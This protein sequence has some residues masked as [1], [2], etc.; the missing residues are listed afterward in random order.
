MCEALQVPT[1]IFLLH[2]EGVSSLSWSSW[3]TQHDIHV[4]SGSLSDIESLCSENQVHAVFIQESL[5][6]RDIE[7]AVALIHQ[8][9]QARIVGMTHASQ[10]NLECLFRLGFDEILT[11]QMSLE[12]QQTRCLK[13]LNEGKKRYALKADYDELAGSYALSQKQNDELILLSKADSLTG[14]FNRRYMMRK[15]QEEA[16]RN[17]RSQHNTFS[18]LVCDIDHFDALNAKEGREIG[19]RVLREVALILTNS[20]RTYDIISRW[21]GDQFMLLLPETDL[22]WALVVADRCK[23]NIERYEFHLGE[24]QVHIQVTIGVAEFR[25]PDGI[26]ECTLRV[27]Q[28]LKEG[29]RRGRNCIVYKGLSGAPDTFQT[30]EGMSSEE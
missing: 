29:K 21:S 7:R 1:T 3:F 15:L 24:S 19:D 20:C 16:L 23:R 22:T 17:Q 27:E 11:P 10:D 6:N 4:Q 13:Q 28:A 12:E 14:L 2:G 18:L 30:Y 25:Q 8:V 9:S 5:S 26:S